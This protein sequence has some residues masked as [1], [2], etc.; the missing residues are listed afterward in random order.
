MLTLEKTQAR[1][2]NRLP[3]LF[4]IE[5]SELAHGTAAA[6]LQIHD[7]LLAP[8]GF[9]HAATV[10]ALADT[11]CGF[12]CIANLPQGAQSFTTLELKSNYL[13]TAREGWISA[14]ASLAHGGRSTQVWDAI[15][16]RDSDAKTIALFRCTQMILYP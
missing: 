9:L 14:T 15:I 11:T 7:A 5:F 1:M 6:R 8:N 16:K 3:E 10:V 2:R 12:G 4:G 13:G